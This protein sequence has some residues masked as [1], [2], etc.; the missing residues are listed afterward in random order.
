MGMFSCLGVDEEAERREREE[1]IAK[2]RA[3]SVVLPEENEALK[4]AAVV[5]DAKFN[6]ASPWEEARREQA[7]REAEEARKARQAEEA[8]QKSMKRNA[9]QDAAAG[10]KDRKRPAGAAGPM[11]MQ[12]IFASFRQKFEDKARDPSAATAGEGDAEKPKSEYQPP[13]TIKK[14]NSVAAWSQRFE[15]GRVPTA[16]KE[17]KSEFEKEKETLPMQTLEERQREIEKR[18]AE[19]LM[20]D[21]F[22]VQV[23]LGKANYRAGSQPRGAKVRRLQHDLAGSTYHFAGVQKNAD[24][25]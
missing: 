17:Y 18:E 7:R 11:K 4:G 21:E 1:M 16:A 5:G 22:K 6:A 13:K 8:L 20:T 24:F 25:E 2:A 19:K 3:Q 12:S 14:E 9:S 23:G 15:K 10:P